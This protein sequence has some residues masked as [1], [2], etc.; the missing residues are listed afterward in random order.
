MGVPLEE[1]APEDMELFYWRHL[2]GVL[3]DRVDRAEGKHAQVWKSLEAA[4]PAAAKFSDEAKKVTAVIAANL[5]PAKELEAWHKAWANLTS[6]QQV[7]EFA[8][9]GG[10]LPHLPHLNTAGA[11]VPAGKPFWYRFDADPK[12]LAGRKLVSHSLSDP[13]GAPYHIALTGGLYSTEGRLRAGGVW[14]SGTSSSTDMQQHGSAGF[15]YT[16][17]N[18]E[19]GHGAQILISPRVLARTSTYG[20]GSD[21][22][23]DIN[24]RKTSAY[25]DLAQAAAHTGG[26]NETEIKDV[27]SLLDDVMLMQVGTNRQKVLDALKARGVTE[28]RGLPVEDRIV[29][30]I[31]PEAIA[32]AKAAE[33]APETW[34]GHPEEPWSP[35]V[36]EA[37]TKEH[38]VVQSQAEKEHSVEATPEDALKNAAYSADHSA[39]AKPEDVSQVFYHA[40]SKPASVMSDAP[41]LKADVAKRVAGK[42]TSTEEQMK[43]LADAAG[44]SAPEGW[45]P[46][47]RS[48]IAAA[49]VAT[50]AQSNSSP[51][52]LALQN[53]A[54]KLF[55]VKKDMLPGL[56]YADASGEEAA[57][58]LEEGFGAVL[59][60]FLQTQ[61]AET[62]AELSQA[63]AEHLTLYRV[64]HFSSVPDW[65][66]SVATGDVIDAPQARPLSSWGFIQAAAESA[67]TFA[68]GGKTVVVKTTVPASMALSFPRTGF[69]CYNESEFVILDAPGSWEI[70]KVSG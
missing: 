33:P 23:G 60:D 19:T 48:R 66:K 15:V 44:L 36:A 61:W 3:A 51:I 45:G 54:H 11:D 68:S 20:F 43:A 29:S 70:V 7:Q 67:G 32:K 28:I 37:V 6:E 57:A 31:T 39:G 25:F 12:W 1:A 41:K 27:V 22:Y 24:N 58:A 69:G 13:A 4:V 2:A 18:Q 42:M 30:S 47:A 16:R 55:G 40:P 49:L 21:N 9:K 35:P 17:L 53:T 14:V 62:Q 38:S 26:S 59:A 52:A 56:G 8:D 50:W 65:A 46:D 64:F 63:G 5:D 10:H 34:F